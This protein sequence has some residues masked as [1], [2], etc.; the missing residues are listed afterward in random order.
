MSERLGFIPA[1]DQ[2]YFKKRRSPIPNDPNTLIPPKGNPLHIKPPQEQFPP[3]K[4]HRQ[5][6]NRDRRRR[7]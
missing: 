5:P 6:N 7:K 1:P 3:L 4:P 2:Q